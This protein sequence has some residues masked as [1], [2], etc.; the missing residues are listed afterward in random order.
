MTIGRV[1]RRIPRSLP[2]AL[3]VI[4]LLPDVMAAK[5]KDVDLMVPAAS[6]CSLNWPDLGTASCGVVG[7]RRNI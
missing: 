1:T 3:E 7:I 2:C 6:L 4:Q 5:T